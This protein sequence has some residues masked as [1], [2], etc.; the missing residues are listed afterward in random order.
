MCL[1]IVSILLLSHNLFLHYSAFNCV[2][3][4]HI[5]FLFDTQI[6]DPEAIIVED[7]YKGPKLIKK[8]DGNFDFSIEFVLEVIEYFKNQKKLHRKYVIE[9]LQEAVKHFSSCPSLQYVT[10]PQYNTNMTVS[11]E[12]IPVTTGSFTVCG[13]TH[14]QFYDLCNIFTLNGYPA[15]DNY[16]LFNGKCVYVCCSVCV[17]YVC[18]KVWMCL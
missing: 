3:I 7:S 17:L 15:D 9:I 1:T 13:D 14:G 12:D 5:L 4:S 2:S 11:L 10:L 8:E 6:I 18:V 16:Y